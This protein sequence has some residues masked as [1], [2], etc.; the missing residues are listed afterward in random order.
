MKKFLCWL[1]GHALTLDVKKV[2]FGFQ[3]WRLRCTRCGVVDPY[4]TERA[5]VSA[6]SSLEAK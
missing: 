1:R 3:V 2:G 5:V 6:T 4:K